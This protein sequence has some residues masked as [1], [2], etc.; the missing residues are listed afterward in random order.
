MHAL[1]TAGVQQA[2][3]AVEVDPLPLFRAA[4]QAVLGQVGPSR[5]DVA[6]QGH[7]D[8]VEVCDEGLGPAGNGSGVAEGVQRSHHVGD[9][10][11]APD[12]LHVDPDLDAAVAEDAVE[13]EAEVS[14]QVG[15]GAAEELVGVLPVDGGR[16]AA[17]VVP[18]HDGAG[19]G[20]GYRPAAAQFGG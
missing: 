6:V 2:V 18:A 16:E 12:V 11:T 13:H 19:C 8:A 3:A 20:Y 10:D 5:P 4:G 14:L 1:P 7:A 15:D 17:D 9:A